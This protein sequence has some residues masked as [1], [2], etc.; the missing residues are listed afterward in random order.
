MDKCGRSSWLTRAAEKASEKSEYDHTKRGENG[1][2]AGKKIV[3]KTETESL[4][5]SEASKIGIDMK[6]R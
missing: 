5:S 1:S 6:R 3:G 4:W 2:T